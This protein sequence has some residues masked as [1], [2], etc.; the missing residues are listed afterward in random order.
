MVLFKE[1]EGQ[2]LHSVVNTE[3]EMWH[4]I[5]AGDIFKVWKSISRTNSKTNLQPK[6]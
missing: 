5:E 3:S 2:G 4:S 1:A 6:R